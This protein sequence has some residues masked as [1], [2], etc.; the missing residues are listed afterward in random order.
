MDKFIFPADFIILDYEADGEVPIIFGRSFLAT[1]RTLIDVQKD[2]L[3]MRVQEE[4]VTFNVFKAMKFASEIEECSAISVVDS[5][6]AEKFE[7]DN[8]E[9]NEEVVEQVEWLEANSTVPR[10][11]RKS[12]SLDLA[13]REH[14]PSRPSS[15]EPPALELK[16]LPAHLR[17]AYLGESSTLPVIISVELTKGQEE[18]MLTILKEFQGAML[19][20]FA[21]IRFSWKIIKKGL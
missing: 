9:E 11:A 6:A 15:E 1:G 19:T 20:R 5:L 7:Q 12:E 16:P 3:T 17:Y 21:C 18:S 13:D 8:L 2:E 4:H 10:F 14:K